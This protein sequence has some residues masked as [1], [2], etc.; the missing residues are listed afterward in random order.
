MHDRQRCDL[1]L[2]VETDI[3]W[4]DLIPQLVWRGTDFMYLSFQNNLER[5]TYEKYIEGRTNPNA[6]QKKA[7]TSILRENFATL[8][9]RWK[10]V[11]YTAESEI[12]AARS[13]TLPQVNCKFSSVP[14]GG[15][16]TSIGAP[17]YKKWEE[18]GFPVAG[19]GMDEDQLSKF[20]YHIDTGGGGG[21]T[22][23]GTVLKLG[24]PGLLF[25]HT[26]PTKDYIF[27]QIQPW[28]HYVPV[29]EDLEDLMEKLE[30]AETHQDQA[31]RISE[32]ATELMKRLSTSEGFEPLFTQ[33]MMNPL[34][35]VIEAYDPLNLRDEVSWNDA[36]EQMGGSAFSPFIECTRE[37]GCRVN[38]PTGSWYKGNKD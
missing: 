12:E 20:K 27:D 7:A 38:K 5:P 9:P 22:W 6:N 21:T 16:H 10:T 32:N 11:V 33:H 2:P 25:H 35:E 1:F 28:V 29:R 30:W 31:R 17:E 19:E 13:N 8:V 37:H 36:F 18:I 4:D 26:T 14:Y 34:L 3:T 24:L 15:K 23:T